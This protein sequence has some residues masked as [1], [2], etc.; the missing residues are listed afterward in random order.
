[1][2][3]TK[4]EN[5]ELL[6]MATCFAMQEAGYETTTTTMSFCLYYLAM[7]PDYQAKVREEVEQA[8]EDKAVSRVEDLDLDSITGGLPYMEMFINET[9]R[10]HPPI[11]SNFRS[12][13]K[14]YK[15][16]DTDI[17]IDPGVE[18][19]IPT[20]IIHLVRMNN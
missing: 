12:C 7:Y 16:P 10:L 14:P 4:R 5:L 11:I 9:L 3:W 20:Q 19:H 8:M 18:I 15:I 17:V 2:D 1:M 13:T 6:L